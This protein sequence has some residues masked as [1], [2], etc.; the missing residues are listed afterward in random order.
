M[1]AKEGC[2]VAQNACRQS[3]TRQGDTVLSLHIGVA[4]TGGDYHP[5]RPDPASIAA[6]VNY[7][8]DQGLQVANG[9]NVIAERC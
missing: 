4:A 7:L 8:A 2:I 3:A 1:P 6:A 9:V 5:A